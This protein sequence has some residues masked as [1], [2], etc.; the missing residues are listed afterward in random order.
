MTPLAALL[1][2]ALGGV[3]HVVSGPDHVAAVMPLSA[4][5]PWRRAAAVGLAWGVGHGLGVVVLVGLG[6]LA[7][8]WFDLGRIGG[9]AEVAVGLLLV[10]LG[11]M[12]LNRARAPERVGHT[13]PHAPSA[14]PDRRHHA[15]LA[16][17]VLHGLGG[18]SH[19]AG[20]LPSLAFGPA[21]AALYGVGYLGAA[22]AMMTGVA[23]IASLGLAAPGRLRWA[24]VG[25]GLGAMGVGVFWVGTALAG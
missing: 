24:L 18:A 13:H 4:G 10:G 11:A 12:T 20:L 2:G 21:A 14:R 23:A 17:G 25:T 3:F 22:I 5:S 16:F 8:G 1:A 19:L 6:Q 9:G 7:R 15:A